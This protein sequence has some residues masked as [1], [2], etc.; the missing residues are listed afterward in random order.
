MWWHEQ[1]KPGLLGEAAS[2]VWQYH[3]CPRLGASH[4]GLQCQLTG[5]GDY[6][7]LS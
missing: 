4:H 1:D 7:R 5:L 3:P 6:K 2:M